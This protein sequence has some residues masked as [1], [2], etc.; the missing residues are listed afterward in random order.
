V[1]KLLLLPR[2]DEISQRDEKLFIGDNPIPQEI[3]VHSQAAFWQRGAAVY[4][5]GRS[6]LPLLGK[7]LFQGS[8]P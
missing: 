6:L 4:C 3:T 1:E 2:V 8:S 5:G 7:D